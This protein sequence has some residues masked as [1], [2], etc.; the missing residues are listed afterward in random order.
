M[1]HKQLVRSSFVLVL[2]ALSIFVRSTPA[3]ALDGGILRV[4]T[5]NGWKAFEVITVGNNPADDG[6]SYSMPGA[7]DGVGAWLTDPSTLRLQINHELTD[8]SISEVD[9]DLSSFQTAISNMISS[10]NTGGGSFVNSARQAYDRWTDDAGSTWTNTSSTS[11]TS[12][13]RFCSGQSYA[14]NTF[15]TDRG[16]VD[17]IYITGEETSGGHLFAI[18]SVNRDFYDLSASTGS[19]SGGFGGMPSDNWENAALLDTGETNHVALM[20]S[21][22]GGSQIMQIYIGEKGKDAS[23]S[24]STS[25]LARNGLAYGSYYYL[26]DKLPNLADPSTDGFFDTTI[27]GKLSSSKLEDIDTSPSNPN[28]VVLGDQD[29]GLF[30]FDFSLDFS[31]GSFNSGTSSFSITKIQNHVDNADGS[32]GDADNVDWVDATTLNGVSYPE[33]LIFVNEDTGTSG[34]EIW[35]MEPDGN[36]LTKIGDTIGI[37]GSTETSGIF[38]VSQMVGYEPGS[39]MLTVNQGANSSM[40]VLIN[41]DA[42]LLA[43]GQPGDFNGDGFVNGADFLAWQRGEVSDP[44]S[45]SD[46]A[47]WEAQYGVGGLASNVASVPEPSSGLLILLASIRWFRCRSSRC[48]PTKKGRGKR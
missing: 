41:P 18:D 15:G 37:S 4:N 3:L 7:F 38:D 31:G 5:L 11:N 19:A 32:F 45:A 12:F 20:L 30:T 48:A 24:A 35:V 13:S 34:G 14:P 40:S 8:A 17:E 39:I 21:L 43:T 46:L 36:G 16:F 28:Q 42:T 6:I 22:D 10:G 2:L 25:F 1:V 47:L 33:G 27:P 44:P 29:S 9:L 23:G 26:N